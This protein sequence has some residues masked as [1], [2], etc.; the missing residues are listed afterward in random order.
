MTEKKPTKSGCNS[1]HYERNRRVI[2]RFLGPPYARLLVKIDRADNLENVPSE[3]PVIVYYNH[4]SFADP[5]TI[6]YVLRRDIVPMA[7]IEVYDYPIIGILPKLWCVVP[8]RRGEA[9]RQAIRASLE[10]LSAGEMLLIAPEGTRGSTLRRGLEG[11]A[12]LACRS[13]AVMVPAAIRHAEGFPT[14]R[15]KKRWQ[16]PGI[17]IRF[18][19]PFRYL[20]ELKRAKSAQLRKMTDEAMYLLAAMLPEEKRGEY[21]DLSQATQETFVWVQGQE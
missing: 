2:R 14:P 5:L 13:G 1:T 20:P 18:G 7:K 10:V 21:A 16:G 3:G 15:F 4:F 19:R 8:V 6:M 9:D 17:R 12:Y 11:M